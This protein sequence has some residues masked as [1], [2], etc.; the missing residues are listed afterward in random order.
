MNIVRSG[1]LHFDSRVCENSKTRINT[2]IFEALKKAQKSVDAIRILR[3]IHKITEFIKL[4]VF[5][6]QERKR[7]LAHAYFSVQE[8]ACTNHPAVEAQSHKRY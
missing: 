2:E 4:D 3:K 1:V 8:Q 7:T 6:L 5:F